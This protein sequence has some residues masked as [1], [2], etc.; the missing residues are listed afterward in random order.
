MNLV[1]YENGRAI[2]SSVVVAMAFR[3]QHKHVIRDI[4]VL[5]SNINVLENNKLTK[6]NFGLSDESQ[7][8]QLEFD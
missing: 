6:P 8:N 7:Q 2:T 4:E 1:I 3:K 5:I